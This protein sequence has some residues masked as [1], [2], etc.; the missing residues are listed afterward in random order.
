[1]IAIIIFLVIWG[2][3]SFLGA[4]LS[5]TFAKTAFQEIGAFVLFLM[6]AVCF[7]GATIIKGLINIYEA[8]KKKDNHEEQNH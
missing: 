1:M 6:S 7:S 4:F 5:L 2:I 3:I 8:I